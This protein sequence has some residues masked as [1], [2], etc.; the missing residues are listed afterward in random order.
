MDFLTPIA[1]ALDARGKIPEPVPDVV[2]T[3]LQAGADPNGANHGANKVLE[4]FLKHSSE[5]TLSR[6][7]LNHVLSLCYFDRFEWEGRLEA[8]KLLERHGAHIDM[9]CPNVRTRLER[10]FIVCDDA[11]LARLSNSRGCLNRSLAETFFKAIEREAYDVAFRLMDSDESLAN[12][13]SPITGW[14]AF[15]YAVDA[16]DVELVEE[17]LEKGADVNRVDE[18]R[19]CR[20]RTTCTTW[21]RDRFGR[22]PTN[23]DDFDPDSLS[24]YCFVRKIVGIMFTQPV[25]DP[26]L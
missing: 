17:P 24:F 20:F 9:D 18:D 10:T 15:R 12:A 26:G 21:H 6:E 3:L 23:P 14:T 16:S 5:K 25:A 4:L 13:V 1:A 22:Y 11:E 7:H 19:I 2:R 8:T